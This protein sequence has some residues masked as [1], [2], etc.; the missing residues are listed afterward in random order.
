MDRRGFLAA[1]AG[2]AAATAGCL[3][4]DEE[5]DTGRVAAGG[6]IGDEGETVASG[7][8]VEVDGGTMRLTATD[9]Q[10]SVVSPQEG[11]TVYEPTDTQF[12]VVGLDTSDLLIESPLEDMSLLL[13]GERPDIPQRVPRLVNLDRGDITATRGSADIA[14]AVPTATPS[15]ARIRYDTLTNVSWRVPDALVDIFE[16]APEFALESAAVVEDNGETALALT[17]ENRGDRDGVF[18]CTT[19]SGDGTPEV[20]RFT[21]SADRQANV[22]IT[23][24]AVSEWPAGADFAHPVDPDTRAFAV[25]I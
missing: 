18:R 12:L 8:V 25:D 14:F 9:V 3:G 15:T 7:A 16:T 21:V 20:V 2:L 24:A 1:G 13:D 22:T 5:V 17:V 10:R 4:T 19:A 6:T 11:N 23:N